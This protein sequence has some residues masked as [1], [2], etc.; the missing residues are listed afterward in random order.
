MRFVMP[1][2]QL[3]MVDSNAIATSAVLLR[4]IPDPAELSLVRE[5]LVAIAPSFLAMFATAGSVETFTAL[6]ELISAIGP[7]ITDIPPRLISS[8]VDILGETMNANTSFAVGI[9]SVLRHIFTLIP[10][11]LSAYIPTIA[12]MVVSSGSPRFI[13][14]ALDM[15]CGAIRGPIEFRPEFVELVTIAFDL[16]ARH[17]SIMLSD[18]KDLIA[19]VIWKGSSHLESLFR[20]ILARAE[21]EC[22]EWESPGTCASYLEIVAAIGRYV[23]GLVEDAVAQGLQFVESEEASMLSIEFW[24]FLEYVAVQY[25][26]M[27]AAKHAMIAM[28]TGSG[29]APGVLVAVMAIAPFLEPRVRAA[30]IAEAR[31]RPTLDECEGFPPQ[32]YDSA[33]VAEQ[34]SVF[35][36]NERLPEWG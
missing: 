7:W 9:R 1:V 16:I 21:E 6:R 3:A 10:V 27:F 8:L 5:H 17:E 35:V 29:F 36:A 30:A 22:A 13:D 24:P 23:P 18:V 33:A 12:G 31:D 2:I 4:A 34:F 26:R 25:P 19:N 14:A 11:D 15:L 28:L 20:E 32:W